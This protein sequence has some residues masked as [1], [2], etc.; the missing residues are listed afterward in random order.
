MLNSLMRLVDLWK[1]ERYFPRRFY[2]FWGFIIMVVIFSSGILFSS[3]EFQ[4]PDR[5]GPKDFDHKVIDAFVKS[6]EMGILTAFR[7]YSEM[8]GTNLQ[9][10][11]YI[12]AGQPFNA[13][14]MIGNYTD[15]FVNYTIICL[16]DYEQKE[17]LFT[18]DQDHV[19][20]ISIKPGEQ[21]IFPL[22][23]IDLKKGAHDFLLLGIRRLKDSDTSEESE[24]PLLFHRAN[25]FVEGY[26]FPQSSYSKIPHQPSKSNAFQIAVNK[27]NNSS[28]FKELYLD[29]I[30][31][32]KNLN[33]YLH[34]SSPY[35]GALP[36]AL[37]LLID[38]KQAF[39]KSTGN[40]NNCV[41][42][43]ILPPKSQ[44]MIEIKIA[45]LTQIES[46]ALINIENPYARLESE[47]GAMAQIP[48][49]VWISNII[50]FQE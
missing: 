15:K 26:S 16:I 39:F 20:L 40:D 46:L 24:Y 3:E 36:S 43:Y 35:T 4:L 47:E 49:R 5:L 8:R 44:G 19:H 41:L 45:L 38:S 18:G 2:A 23:L 42:Y 25:I 9:L 28:N 30:P 33:Y 22:K 12:K 1:M 10:T 6:G 29:I 27:S 32:S 31:S 13:D 11:Y 21:K 50:R 17:F 7:G 37:V 48:A 34:V 14:F